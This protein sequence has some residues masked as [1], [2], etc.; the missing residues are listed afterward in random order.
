MLRI[1]PVSNNPY[2]NFCIDG[3]KTNGKRKRIFCRTEK[4][5]KAEL[6][7][8]DAQLRSEGEAS[9]EVSDTTRVLG[10]EASE[11]LAPY[12]KNILDAARFYAAH[13]QSLADSVPVSQLVDEYQE[14][15]RKA[16]G[17]G[18]VA[19]RAAFV[20]KRVQRISAGRTLVFLFAFKLGRGPF[21]CRGLPP[22]RATAFDILKLAGSSSH[23][24]GPLPRRR[25]P[26]TIFFER[27]FNG[28]FVCPV[29]GIS[30]FETICKIPL[31]VPVPATK[32]L[33]S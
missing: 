16:S 1:V 15:K 13:L 31:W 24:I 19:T 20:F 8:I 25:F 14:A 29:L 21:C 2:Y 11:L 3:I 10:K 32:S 27:C 33:C 5:A 6:K 26:R 30:I 9:L 4:E 23:L 18:S 12:G 28:S 22:I 7:R 17:N